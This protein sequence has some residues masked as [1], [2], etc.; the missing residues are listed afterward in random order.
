MVFFSCGASTRFRVMASL[1]GLR[2]H[3]QTHHTRQDSSG[4]VVR[5]TQTPLLDNTQHSQETDIH[6]PGGIQ[7]HIPSKLAAPNPL[8]RR[9]GQRYWQFYGLLISNY[10]L[11]ITTFL[12]VSFSRMFLKSETIRKMIQTA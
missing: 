3:T 11:I 6:A 9:R 4:Q 7:T 10:T 8:L 12:N 1:T 5:P 2:D